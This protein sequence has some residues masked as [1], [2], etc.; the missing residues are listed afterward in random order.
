MTLWQGLE[1]LDATTFQQIYLTYKTTKNN[2]KQFEQQ[3]CS[4]TYSITFNNKMY[5]SLVSF[6][7]FWVPLC[8]FSSF[9]FLLAMGGDRVQKGKIIFGKLIGMKNCWWTRKN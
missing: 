2:E 7:I 9:Q 6:C 8:E 4:H 1:N 3:W 5:G